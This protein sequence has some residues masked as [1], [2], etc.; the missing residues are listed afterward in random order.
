MSDIPFGLAFIRYSNLG[1]IMFVPLAK[2]FPVIFRPYTGLLCWLDTFMGLCFT[3]SLFVHGL[4]DGFVFYT[5]FIRPW[6][7][8][9]F[10]RFIIRLFFLLRKTHGRYIL[11]SKDF[12][13]PCLFASRGSFWMNVQ[14]MKDFHTI[15][16][17]LENTSYIYI[18]I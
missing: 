1:M 4:D 15:M 10:L 11:A 3:Q 17:I 18:Y 9:I 14:K 6:L 8:R 2:L 7:G 13:H 16:Y 5:I 12:I